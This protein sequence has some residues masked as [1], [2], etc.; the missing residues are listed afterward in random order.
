MRKP[1]YRARQR[2][3]RQTHPWT[4]HVEWAQRRCQDP[5]HSHGQK[6]IS[7][8]ITYAQ[9]KVLWFRDSAAAMACPSLDRIDPAKDYTFDN[10]RFIEKHINERLPH[11]PALRASLALDTEEEAGLAGLLPHIELPEEPPF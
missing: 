9:A 3:Y 4:R 10:C 1:K 7:R 11:D 5:E 8:H 6:G 2:R